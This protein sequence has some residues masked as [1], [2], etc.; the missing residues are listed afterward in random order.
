[1]GAL[2]LGE[3]SGLRSPDGRFV[4]RVQGDGNLVVYAPDN[5]LIWQSHSS[6]KACPPFWLICSAER[7]AL[8]LQGYTFLPQGNAPILTTI[9]QTVPYR[10]PTIPGVFYFVDPTWSLI[11]QSDALR[12]VLTDAGELQAQLTFADLRPQVVI[13][14]SPGHPITTQPIYSTTTT[15][16]AANPSSSYAFNTQVRY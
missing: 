2:G 15:L 12:L 14:S 1:M 13:W 9:W 4:F 5:V 6:G 7:Y 8:L 11:Q 16:P 10:V 3:A